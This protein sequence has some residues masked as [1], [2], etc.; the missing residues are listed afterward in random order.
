MAT[1]QT[2]WRAQKCVWQL[3]KPLGEPKNAYGN[4]ANRLGQTAWRAQKCVW[5]LGKPLGEPKN[6]YGNSANRLASPKMRMATR[7]TAWRAQKQVW[8]NCPTSYGS[9]EVASFAGIA[10]GYADE[11]V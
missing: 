6:A 10:E 5:Q 7:Q 2:A 11:S 3:G 9:R 8:Q 4:S 1:R